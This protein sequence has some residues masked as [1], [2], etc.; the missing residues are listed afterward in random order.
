MRRDDTSALHRS[1]VTCHVSQLN[2]SIKQVHDRGLPSSASLHSPSVD[3]E[4]FMNE[5][6]PW[7]SDYFTNLATTYG[8]NYLAAPPMEKL[9]KCQLKKVCRAVSVRLTR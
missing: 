7:I 5:V 1:R 4:T 2:L 9:R 8:S 6:T 3:A